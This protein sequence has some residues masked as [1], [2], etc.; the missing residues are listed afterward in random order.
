MRTTAPLPTTPYIT[1]SQPNREAY[2]ANADEYTWTREA[3]VNG[4]IVELREV[5]DTLEYLSRANMK[6][7]EWY[8]IKY[9]ADGNVRKVVDID[10]SVASDKYENT[11]AQVEDVV[12]NND[13]VLLADTT[14]VN[15]L[16]F[17]NGTLYTSTH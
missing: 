16:E 7:G 3:V 13:T 12:K 4:E 10:F 15:R 2:D 1:S 9:D 11:V 6:Q 14:T 5:G 17:K 8:E